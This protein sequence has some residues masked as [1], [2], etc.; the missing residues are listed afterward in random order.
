MLAILYL[1]CDPTPA[2][3]TSRQSAWSPSSSAALAAVVLL[4]P[5]GG[6]AD[7]DR[8]AA[9][10]ERLRLDAAAEYDRCVVEALS[11]VTDRCYPGRR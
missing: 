4:G 10:L 8:S 2:T 11:K 1:I 9:A 5:G 7:R 3:L 6:S